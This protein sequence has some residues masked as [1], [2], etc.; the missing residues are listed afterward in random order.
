MGAQRAAGRV[1]GR[2]RLLSPPQRGGGPRS[3]SATAAVAAAPAASSASVQRLARASAREDERAL[4]QREDLQRC[5]SCPLLVGSG[6]PQPCRERRQPALEHLVGGLAQRFAG[7]GDL[8]G[9][10]GDRTGVGEVT[11]AQMLGGR[12]EEVA[13]AAE[14]IRSGVDHGVDEQ[15]VQGPRVTD[16][17]HA[18]LLLTA[19]EMVVDRAEGRLC[20]GDDLLDAGARVSLAPK[21]LGAGV[22]DPVASV[23]GHRLGLPLAN[24][25]SYST[26]ERSI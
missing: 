19:G 1:A 11:V 13:H 2:R 6:A 22:D 21:Q 12:G 5:C 16:R 7:A 15:R 10:G 14:E 3:A 23:G 9:N 25:H 17:L 8:Q 18:D 4:Q 26:L 20:R 24:D